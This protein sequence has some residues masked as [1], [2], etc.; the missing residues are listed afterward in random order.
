MS[1]SAI[2]TNKQLYTTAILSGRSAC[3]ILEEPAEEGLG[4]EAELVCDLLNCEA[5]GVEVAL[6]FAHQIVGNDLL[7]R[8][9][10]DVIC[11]L[12]EVATRY[13][14]LFS[15][16]RNIMSLVIKLGNKTH[17]SIVKVD[18]TG[19]FII[20]IL[21]INHLRMNEVMSVSNSCG[22]IIAH[23]KP[24]SNS[25]RERDSNTMP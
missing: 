13:A 4:G 20:G 14:K 2:K 7:G 15:I 25:C 16:E 18:G 23:T 1:S 11:Y 3:L 9:A 21:G 6:G 19:V 17:E 24:H 12:R 22:N 8:L 5:S 10:Y